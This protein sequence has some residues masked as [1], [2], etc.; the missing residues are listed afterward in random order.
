MASLVYLSLSDTAKSSEFLGVSFYYEWKKKSFQNISSKF[1]ILLHCSDMYHL[2]IPK[3]SLA[4]EWYYHDWLKDAFGI[5]STAN[6][7]NKIKILLKRGKKR[8]IDGEPSTIW[9]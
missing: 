9:I 3:E 7:P 5:C 6:Y 4:Q 8:I 2:S 1:P